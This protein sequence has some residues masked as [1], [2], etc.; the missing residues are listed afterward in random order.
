MKGSDPIHR[1]REIAGDDEA[2]P[3]GCAQNRQL[4]GAAAGQQEQGPTPCPL[5]HSVHAAGDYKF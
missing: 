1:G 2:V 4:L 3:A 5:G